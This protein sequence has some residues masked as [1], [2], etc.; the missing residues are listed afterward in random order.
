MAICPERW[1]KR[2]WCSTSRWNTSPPPSASIARFE[3]C[4][5]PTSRFWMKK[6][7][8]SGAIGISRRP[9]KVRCRTNQRRSFCDCST[10]RWLA[11]WLRMCRWE[12]FSAGVWIPPRCALSRPSPPPPSS[13]PPFAPS[14]HTRPD[15]RF[16]RWPRPVSSLMVNAAQLLP[17]AETHMS[18]DFRLKQLLRG[19]SAPAPLRHQVWIGAFVP[20]ELQHL[21]HPD[22]LTRMRD[23]VVYRQV[24]EDARRAE[25]AGIGS[26]SI[27]AALRFYLD[28]Y[29]VDDILVKADR[30]S[31]A[32]SLELRAPFL[33]TH[34]G[35]FAARL[36][37]G[38]KLGVWRTKL[39]LQRA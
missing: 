24:L 31:M 8:G 35:E 23:E 5:L 29:L 19:I 17:S 10:V 18:L 13:P 3:S 6:G 25:A 36:P 26:D 9:P 15:C 32:A 38:R 1:T 2:R 7:F 20:S 39:I 11:V 34:V 16:A 4:R 27:D 14:P 33:D 21:L 12:S 22:L 37:S 30:A 28:R